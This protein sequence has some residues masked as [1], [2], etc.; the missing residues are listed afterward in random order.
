MKISKQV[1]H[2]VRYGKSQQVIINGQIMEIPPQ[3]YSTFAC[4]FCGR[5]LL[6]L[7]EEIPFQK[8][9]ETVQESKD[10]LSEEYP[11]CPDCGEKLDWDICSIID[12][13]PIEVKT[14]VL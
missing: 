3:P 7:Q 1:K 6:Q 2:V 10:K 14:E 13:E 4:P 8:M 12:V 5:T 9:G 11:F